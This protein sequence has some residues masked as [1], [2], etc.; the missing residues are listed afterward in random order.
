MSISSSF[1]RESFQ[2][3]LAS[4]FVVQ[5]YL[6]SQKAKR[7]AVAG[8]AKP[9]INGP[10][11]A[12]VEI[13]ELIGT[14]DLNVDDAMHVIADRARK[15]AN[16]PGVAIALL[17]GD[18]LVYRA[19]SGSAATYIGRQV[20]AMLSLSARNRASGEILRVENAQTDRRIE[21]AIC[22]QFGAEAL[23]ILPI[24]H[25]RTVAGVLEVLFSQAHAFQDRE[26]RTYQLM[27]GLVAEAMSHAAQR[28]AVE[29]VAPQLRR[30]PNDRGSAPGPADRHV[31]CQV[32][33]AA[34]VEAGELPAASQRAGTATMITQRAKRVPLHQQ[35]WEA[36]LA[37]VALVMVLAMAGWIT[38]IDRPASRLQPTAMQRSNV[39]EQQA[40]FVPAKPLPANSTSEPQ[41]APRWVQVEYSR[42]DYIAEDVTVH[43]VTPKPAVVPA[44]QPVGSAAQPVA[45]RLEP[46]VGARAADKPEIKQISMQEKPGKKQISV[47]GK[48]SGRGHLG[49][50]VLGWLHKVCPIHMI[51]S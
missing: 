7:S 21:A 30:L 15:V 48:K 17:K 45:Q 9:A 18:E 8:P 31:I 35:R 39:I 40:V 16:A 38:S 4:A 19:G 13:Q 36:A 1:A 22:R 37:A 3:L 28:Q 12:I 29:Q 47:Q 23:L 11:D 43:Y 5:E 27:A 42:D 26:V 32:C 49:G 46:A 51:R 44:K 24:Y 33:G 25:D 34:M 6:E 2:K 14:G 41:T 10:K 20:K 50:R